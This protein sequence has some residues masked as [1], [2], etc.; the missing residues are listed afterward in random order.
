[1]DITDPTTFIDRFQNGQP[2][3]THRRSRV[4]KRE[5]VARV[6]PRIEEFRRL[7]YS[8]EGIAEY[9]GTLGV[10]LSVPTLKNYMRRAKKGT[11]P[12]RATA[13]S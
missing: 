2:A 12:K 7:G 10:R 5:L 3:D 13:R 9:F 8:W 6:K 4:T 11:T 1:M